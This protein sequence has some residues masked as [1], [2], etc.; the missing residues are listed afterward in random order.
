VLYSP[1]SRLSSQIGPNL[2]GESERKIKRDEERG[3][4]VREKENN[5]MSRLQSKIS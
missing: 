2:K 3:N 4:R 5:K 1:K